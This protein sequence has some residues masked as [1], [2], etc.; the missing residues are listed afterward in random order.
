MLYPS[1]EFETV[2][3]G[4]GIQRC[5]IQPV[6]LI[7]CGLGTFTQS[8]GAL[9]ITNHMAGEEGICLSLPTFWENKKLEKYGKSR[10]RVGSSAGISQ[11]FRYLSNPKK[12]FTRNSFN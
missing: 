1:S 3:E 9:W 4:T 7:E 5:S 10:V 11:S 12:L 8:V 6:G 2:L